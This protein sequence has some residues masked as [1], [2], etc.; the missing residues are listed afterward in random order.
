MQ[1][2][3]KVLTLSILGEIVIGEDKYELLLNR[4]T[5]KEQK[6]IFKKI[7]E[8]ASS[9][10]ELKKIDGI[11]TRAET[12]EEIYEKQLKLEENEAKILVILE[13][14]STNLDLVEGYSENYGALKTKAINEDAE[15]EYK[16]LVEM[17]VDKTSIVD[18]KEIAEKYG[19]TQLYSVISGLWADAD[20]K[21]AKGS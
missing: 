11:L 10:V 1:K 6:P 4:A 3:T 17:N 13:K 8:K 14:R 18:A 15:P 20:K 5:R 16:K 19:W 21:N 12:R 7:N 9:Q 2:I